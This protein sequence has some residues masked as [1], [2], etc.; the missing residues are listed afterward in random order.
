MRIP[1]IFNVSQCSII[2]LFFNHLKM[3]KLYL[4][5]RLYKNRRQC[6]SGL[7]VTVCWPPTVSAAYLPPSNQKLP[8]PL[9]DLAAPTLRSPSRPRSALTL[10]ASSLSCPLPEPPQS[11]D[12]ILA[13]VLGG[14]HA[15]LKVALVVGKQTKGLPNVVVLHA[16]KRSAT[17]EWPSCSLPNGQTCEMPTLGFFQK[18]MGNFHHFLFSFCHKTSEEVCVP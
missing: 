9:V 17:S 12:A 2:F 14:W 18:K 16:L 8:L 3:W 1:L 13:F 7:G 11:Q 6:G 10:W 15:Y 5:H 4:A